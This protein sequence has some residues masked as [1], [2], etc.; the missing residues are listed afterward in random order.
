[1]DNIRKNPRKERRSLLAA[2]VVLML[3]TT[4]TA[5]AAQTTADQVKDRESLKAFVVH[6]KRYLESLTDFNDVMAFR[7]TCRERPT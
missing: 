2:L 6:A 1:M 3:A 7:D 4:P 5:V